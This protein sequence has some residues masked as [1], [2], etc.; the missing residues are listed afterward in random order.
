MVP[1]LR[2]LLSHPFAVTAGL[3]LLPLG[4]AVIA[5]F[6]FAMQ[7]CPLCIYQRWPY[8]LVFL[9]I[10]LL[11]K[12]FIL[13]VCLLLFLGEAGLASYH[14]AVEWGIVEGTEG[15]RLTFAY[16]KEAPPW[17]EVILWPSPGA[18]C[19]QADMRWLGLSMAGWNGLYA[20]ACAVI[21][22]YLWRRNR[23][24]KAHG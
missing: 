7:P 19:K 5:Q 23:K 10:L 15:C 13:L 8:L 20:L 12:P 6:G 2:T 18:G 22:G 4:I 14:A 16:A 9:L 3:A 1:F 24:E 11:R 17:W 21:C